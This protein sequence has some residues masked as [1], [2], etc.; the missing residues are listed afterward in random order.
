MYFSCTYGTFLSVYNEASLSSLFCVLQ[1]CGINFSL[2]EFGI[3]NSFINECHIRNSFFTMDNIPSLGQR[4]MMD[5]LETPRNET[6]N[7]RLNRNTITLA[8]ETCK[9]PGPHQNEGT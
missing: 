7:S 8:K 4:T 5:I 1:K 6:G 9:P 2:N 3:R